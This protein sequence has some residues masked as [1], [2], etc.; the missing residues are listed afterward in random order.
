MDRGEFLDLVGIVKTLPGAIS[1]QFA[2]YVGYKTAG[3]FG[4]VSAVLGNILPPA[5]FILPALFLYN[6]HK[7]IVWV[8]NGFNMV[9]VAIAAM[10]VMTILKIIDYRLIINIK[11]FIVL[12]STILLFLLTRLHPAFILIAAYIFGALYG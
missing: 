4:I 1:I 12:I 7:D 9:K 3:F 2:T 6:K 10:V 5:I 8:R 11:G